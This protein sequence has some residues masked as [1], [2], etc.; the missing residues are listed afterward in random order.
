MPIVINSKVS[1]SYVNSLDIKG[2][3]EQ[4]N[5]VIKGL[6]S[7]NTYSVS[8]NMYS[9]STNTYSDNQYVQ[10]SNQYLQCS[11]QYLQ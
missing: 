10:C 11:N 4:L 8:T 3:E 7:T 9:V 1:H 2:G 6:L 5:N